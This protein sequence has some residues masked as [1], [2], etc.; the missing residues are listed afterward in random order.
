MEE[1]HK[2]QHGVSMQKRRVLYSLLTT[3]T[4]AFGVMIGPSAAATPESLASDADEYT[5]EYVSE[6]GTRT[7]FTGESSTENYGVLAAGWASCVGSS[8]N[9]LLKSY[10]AGRVP[11]PSLYIR[12]VHFR[13]GNSSFGYRHIDA[14]HGSQWQTIASKIG[15]NWREFTDWV[16]EQSLTA[17]HS[18]CQS[19]PTDNTI[20]Y[21]GW[22]QIKNSA[23]V[24]ISQYY[25]RIVTGKSTYNLITAFPQTLPVTG[26]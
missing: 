5:I 13:C 11:M 12:T 18:Y 20:N 1:S 10:S 21:V 19:N 26:C 16:I 9:Q 15:A 8:A 6:D 25:P 17:P 14:E 3:I 2:P 22:V 24:V 4:V 7:A 23:G